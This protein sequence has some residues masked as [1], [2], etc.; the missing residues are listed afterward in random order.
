MTLLFYIV[1]ILR[2][3]DFLHYF[4]YYACL[5]NIQ[6]NFIQ[7]HKIYGSYLKQ[8]GSSLIMVKI[9]FK[10]LKKSLCIF[11]INVENFEVKRQG[12]QLWT[13]QNMSSEDL[14][15]LNLVKLVK[16]EYQNLG[17]SEEVLLPNLKKSKMELPVRVVILAGAVPYI[18]ACI[19][20]LE[21]CSAA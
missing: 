19:I 2:L 15:S 18:K 16:R 13:F 6:Q 8:R 11:I 14:E 12:Q 3:I 4:C 5:K 20:Y 9:E 21:C 17:K 7:P 10:I 1:F